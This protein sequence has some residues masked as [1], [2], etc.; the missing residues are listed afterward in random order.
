MLITE[1]IAVMNADI[2]DFN[3]PIQ[4]KT[5]HKDYYELYYMGEYITAGPPRELQRAIRLAAAIY[6]KMGWG[7]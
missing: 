2:N 6:D 7:F 1:P 5:Q 4:L 3:L